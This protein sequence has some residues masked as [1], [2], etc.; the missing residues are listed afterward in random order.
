MATS[1]PTEQSYSRVDF[2]EKVKRERKNQGH[3]HDRNLVKTSGEYYIYLLDER[4]MTGISQ[5]KKKY[6]LRSENVAME[7]R[8]RWRW[9]KRN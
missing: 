5:E 6:S 9:R 1:T 8:A 2:E 7:K 4:P 3:F